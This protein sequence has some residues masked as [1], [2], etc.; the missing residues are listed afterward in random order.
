MSGWIEVI[1]GSMFSGKTEELIRRLR[2][3]Q[4]AKLKVQ[5]FKPA[6]DRRYHLANVTS[7]NQTSIQ[8]TP[9]QSVHDLWSCL[10][11]DTQVVG[12]DEGQFLTMDL[13]PVCRDLV[14]RGVRV[15]VAGLDMDW[16]AQPFEPIPTLMALAEEVTKHRAIC[17]RCGELAAYTQKIGG[18]DSKIEVG[19]QDF[20][21]ARCRLHFRPIVEEVSA[22]SDYLTVK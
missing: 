5:A 7:H 10:E 16:R 18:S 11:P 8:A 15:I 12:F 22:I 17:T 6:I 13:V 20:Y 4:Y 3:A 9:L 14:A 19:S 1:A 2:R 21:E